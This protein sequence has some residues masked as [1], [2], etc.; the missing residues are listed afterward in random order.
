M[1]IGKDDLRLKLMRKNA[2]R[3]EHS[4]DDQKV[5]DLRYKLTKTVRPPMH[6]SNSRQRL[7]Q[8]KEAG[9]YSQIPSTRSADDLSRMDSLRNSYSPW[10]VDHVRRRSPDRIPGPSR[11]LSPQR[12][13]EEI[14]RRPLNRTLDDG[15]SVA[16]MSKDVIDT[17][18]PMGSV[19]FAPNSAL[20]PGSV[21]P[22]APHLS[23]LPPPG[24]IASKS[25]YMV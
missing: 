9:V 13:V 14:R 21:K 10:A 11:G 22:V 18:R 12:N 2:S 3:R 16:Y 1:R 5:G 24:A 15:R 4:N 25:S 7:P 20:P 8:S 19:A 17:K 23:Q 6:S